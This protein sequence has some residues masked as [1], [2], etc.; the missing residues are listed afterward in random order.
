MQFPLAT[1]MMIAVQG[2]G[3]TVYVVNLLG[4]TFWRFGYYIRFIVH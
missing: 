2:V 4:G 1:L 3:E